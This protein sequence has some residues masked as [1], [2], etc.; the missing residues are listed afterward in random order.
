MKVR[1]IVE[2]LDDNQ[3]TLNAPVK[4]ETFAVWI[5]HVMLVVSAVQILVWPMLELVSYTQH[6]TA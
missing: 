1:F 6:Q 2:I 4:V 3:K 5:L